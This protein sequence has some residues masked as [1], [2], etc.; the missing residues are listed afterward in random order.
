MEKQHSRHKDGF[1][2]QEI[3]LYK[4]FLLELMKEYHGG[5]NG[6]EQEIDLNKQFFSKLSKIEKKVMLD[7]LFEYARR[8][9]FNQTYARG[10]TVFHRA[11]MSANPNTGILDWLWN[12]AEKGLLNRSD[13]CGKTAFDYAMENNN[14]DIINWFLAHKPENTVSTREKQL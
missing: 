4:Q 5:Y 10:E 3:D 13:N 7:W 6:Q 8:G 1:N 11:V 12:N 9:L 2:G 14:A